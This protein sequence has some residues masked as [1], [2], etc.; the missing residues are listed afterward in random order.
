MAAIQVRNILVPEVVVRQQTQLLLLLR[1]PAIAITKKEIPEI[2][3]G[4]YSARVTA[5]TVVVPA[6]IPGLIIQATLTIQIIAP[7]TTTAHHLPPAAVP[8]LHP[9][10]VVLHQSGSFKHTSFIDRHSHV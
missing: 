4:K 1:N 7:V 2:L 10:A 8:P 9:E 5:I 3:Y 6:A